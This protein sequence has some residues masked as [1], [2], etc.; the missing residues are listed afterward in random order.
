MSRNALGL[1]F[2]SADRLFKGVYEGVWQLE[3]SSDFGDIL[4]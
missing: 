4:T 1:E 3:N 2:G